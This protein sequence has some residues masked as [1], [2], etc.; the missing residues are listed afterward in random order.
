MG[1]VIPLGG[2]T[3]PLSG[4]QLVQAVEPC[5]R[6]GQ[7]DLEV[8]AIPQD[9]FPG[10]RVRHSVALRERDGERGFPLVAV[11][12]HQKAIVGLQDNV[13]LAVEVHS[14]ETCDA[15]K[16]L[17]AHD[18]H[19]TVDRSP[20]ADLFAVALA[21]RTVASGSTIVNTGPNSGG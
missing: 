17:W 20:V 6:P 11:V 7:C 2:M 13:L 21:K 18:R 9:H 19:R 15:P 4:R 10:V 1:T 12:Q 16:Q 5:L 14:R 3:V 8:G